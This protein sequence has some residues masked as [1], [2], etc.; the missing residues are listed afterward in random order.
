MTAVCSQR[1][2]NNSARYVIA[3]PFVFMITTLTSHRRS[4]SDYVIFCTMPTSRIRK[5]KVRF[6]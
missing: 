1:K 4:K 3:F 2:K 6:Q 5:I